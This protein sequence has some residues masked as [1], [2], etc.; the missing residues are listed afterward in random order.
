MSTPAVQRHAPRSAW[1][2]LC[3][4]GWHD[5]SSWQPKQDQHTT[6][7]LGSPMGLQTYDIDE[8]QCRRCFR[9]RVRALY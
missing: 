2:L 5:W 9:R 7:F 6:F 4:L 1:S 8:R 3:R